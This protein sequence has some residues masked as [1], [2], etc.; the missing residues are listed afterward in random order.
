[1]PGV[2]IFW[3]SAPL[4]TDIAAATPEATIIFHCAT[5]M[6]RKL[7]ADIVPMAAWTKVESTLSH[8]SRLNN[9]IVS[10]VGLLHKMISASNGKNGFYGLFWLFWGRISYMCCVSDLC[11]CAVL[12]FYC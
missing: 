4:S 5:P 7:L 10:P 2:P 8:R 6:S 12:V 9:D 3:A 11:V 1:M